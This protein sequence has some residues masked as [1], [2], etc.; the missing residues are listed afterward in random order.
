ME[1]FESIVAFKINKELCKSR[2][3]ALY[4]N[5]KNLELKDFAHI[6]DPKIPGSNNIVVFIKKLFP[7]FRG[8]FKYLVFKIN[9]CF[10]FEHKKMYFLRK[11]QFS[12]LPKCFGSLG[13]RLLKTSKT[14]GKPTGIPK[15]GIPVEYR[16]SGFP[17]FSK[18]GGC[19]EPDGSRNAGGALTIT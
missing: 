7:R 2:N 14:L 17:L 6:H 3:E 8:T 11:E 10:K 13:R 4:N 18:I 1:V 19:D 9:A 12:K 16:F 5:G 15:F